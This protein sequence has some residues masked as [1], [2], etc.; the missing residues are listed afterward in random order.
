MRNLVLKQLDRG[1]S[2]LWSVKTYLNTPPEGWVRSIRKALGM[3]A[4]QL[5]DRLGFNRSRIIKIENSELKGAITLTTLKEVATALNCEFVYAFLPK[6]TLQKTL[7][8]QAMRISKDIMERIAH[9]MALEA[10]NLT[11]A[12]QSEQ[13]KELVKKLLSGSLKHLWNED[14]INFPTKRNLRSKKKNI[15]VKKTLRKG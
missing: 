3:T 9:T 1:S 14:P 15:I 10:Q 4:V 2:K 7:E 5:A 12:Q 11:N 13:Q 8:L 6:K